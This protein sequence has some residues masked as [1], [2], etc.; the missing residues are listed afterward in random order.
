M[1]N[2]YF[3]DD[4]IKKFWTVCV[5]PALTHRESEDKNWYMASACVLLSI[6]YHSTSDIAS[7]LWTDGPKM[8]L[9]QLSMSHSANINAASIW[10]HGLV[11]LL[12]FLMSPF[13]FPFWRAH[14]IYYLKGRDFILNIHLRPRV[15]YK[16]V[17]PKPFQC[18]VCVSTIRSA[19]V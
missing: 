5:G 1:S 8:P 13:I 14:Y 18:A 11:S 17:F 15:P 3:L 7:Q 9:I 10:G 12:I 19:V 16:S 4:W 2:E 6:S